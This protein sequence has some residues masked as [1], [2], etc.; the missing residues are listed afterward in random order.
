MLR[1]QVVLD[2]APTRDGSADRAAMMAALRNGRCY[3]ARP[4]LGPPTGF[5]FTGSDSSGRRSSMGDE[6]PTGS[7]WELEARV[8]ADAEL[9]LIGGGREVARTVGRTLAHHVTRP[10]AYRVEAL[11]R[12]RRWIVSNPIY[13]R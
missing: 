8:P 9:R 6:T 3:L 4:D 12:A 11:R 13:L 2:R 10:A 5:S 1:T 7:G